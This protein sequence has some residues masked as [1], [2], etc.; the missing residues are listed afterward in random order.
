MLS[1]PLVECDEPINDRQMPPRRANTCER[2]A[3]DGLLRTSSERLSTH[4]PQ[5]LELGALR[6]RALVIKTQA[7]PSAAERAGA[8]AHTAAPGHG[9][10][11]TRAARAKRSAWARGAGG[12]AYRP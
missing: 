3:R 12:S 1:V 2:F 6:L 7:P 10:G 5:P 11:S 9:L 4:R 8:Q